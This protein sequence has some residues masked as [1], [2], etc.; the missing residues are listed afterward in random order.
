MKFIAWLRA[1]FVREKPDRPRSG[2]ADQPLDKVE[3]D[4][5]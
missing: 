5:Q 4:I 3:F 2:T 1:A